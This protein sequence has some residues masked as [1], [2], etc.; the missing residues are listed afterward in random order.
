MK[1]CHNIFINFKTC[2]DSFTW[3]VLVCFLYRATHS[4]IY[5]TAYTDACKTYNTIPSCTTTFLKT[6]HQV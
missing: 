5:K 1:Q 6:N 3:E 2:Q 4:S